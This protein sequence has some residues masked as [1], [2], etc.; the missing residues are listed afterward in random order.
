MGA[1]CHPSLEQ[2]V[3]PWLRLKNLLLYWI[4]NLKV[5][6]TYA[7]HIIASHNDHC[8]LRIGESFFQNLPDVWRRLICKSNDLRPLHRIKV[9][10]PKKIED[11][12]ARFGVPPMD[13]KNSS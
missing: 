2:D 1:E 6:P 5:T 3:C 10:R 8:G 11:R 4:V 7:C 13:H 9:D 12:I